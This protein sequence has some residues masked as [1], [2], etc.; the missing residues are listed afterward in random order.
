[1]KCKLGVDMYML[2][3]LYQV[4]KALKHVKY[5]HYH[6]RLDNEHEKTMIEDRDTHQ[7][8]GAFKSFSSITQKPFTSMFTW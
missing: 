5:I 2:W 8:I 7:V 6:R 4:T 3:P 1:M